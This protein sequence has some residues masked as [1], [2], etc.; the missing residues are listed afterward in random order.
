[1]PITH[2]GAAPNADDDPRKI[3]EALRRKV[4]CE[5]GELDKWNKDSHEGNKKV[6]SEPVV[7]YR[8]SYAAGDAQDYPIRCIFV[9]T[10]NDVESEYLPHGATR[11]VSLLED[12]GYLERVTGGAEIDGR[13]LAAGVR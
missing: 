13:R 9:G 11:I 2:F 7:R 3:G 4:V 8:K 6:I 1:M 12:H 5:W 10:T